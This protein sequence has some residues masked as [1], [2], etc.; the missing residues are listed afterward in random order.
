MAQHHTARELEIEALLR[1]SQWL[2]ELARSLVG[3][4]FTAE[5]L[6]QEA[7]SHA[8]KEA[9]WATGHLGGWVAGI[10]RNLAKQHFRKE[11]RRIAREQEAAYRRALEHSLP[12][13]TQ[14]APD[15]AFLAQK[16]EVQQILAQ[17]VL[18]L[19]LPSREVL[20]LRYY[21]DRSTK[22]IAAQLNL[23][24]SAVET[25][26]R[27]A[28]TRLRAQME[29]TL[30]KG[31]WALA[32]MPLLPP[33][34][35]PPPQPVPM[36]PTWVSAT[37][38][39]GL[40]LVVAMFGGWLPWQGVDLGQGHDLA[41]V[42]ATDPLMQ[43]GQTTT[44]IERNP[45]M[46]PPPGEPS[47]RG[48]R[49]H[50]QVLESQTNVPL[51]GLKPRF[52]YARR[53]TQQELAIQDD[54]S[55]LRL[56]SVPYWILRTEEGL[57][58]EQ[59]LV[60]LKPPKD[61]TVVVLDLALHTETHSLA[62]YSRGHTA[63]PLPKKPNQRIALEMVPR[64]GQASG[65]VVNPKGDPIPFAKVD[66]VPTV[67]FPKEDSISAT[68]V[69]DAHGRF[70]MNHVASNVGG[71]LLRPR[72]PG[73]VPARQ[74]QINAF[75]DAQESLADIEL[76]LAAVVTAKVVVQDARG[77][78]I[79]NAMVQAMDSLAVF[80]LPSFPGGRYQSEWSSTTQSNP[81]GIAE[82][83][84]AENQGVH[85]EVHAKDF[86]PW[87]QRFAA[88][89]AIVP[90]VLLPDVEVRVMVTADGKPIP[91]AQVRMVAQRH[92]T[93]R[94]IGE[95]AMTDAQGQALFRHARPGE[96]VEFAVSAPGYEVALSP[97][98]TILTHGQELSIPLSKGLS[99][100]GQVR[101]WQGLYPGRAV[102][103]V[104]VL[105]VEAQS[106]AWDQPVPPA[107]RQ[108]HRL[109]L[110]SADR[111]EIQQDGSFR[112][113]GLAPGR[114]RIWFGKR[115][116]P[117]GVTEVMAG[118]E[119]VVLTPFLNAQTTSVFHGVVRDAVTLQPVPDVRLILT[120]Y[121]DRGMPLK[122]NRGQQ[123]PPMHRERNPQGSY[124]LMAREPGWYSLAA[125][126]PSQGYCLI[127][128]RP[129]YFAAGDHQLDFQL[130]ESTALNFRVENGQGQSLRGVKVRVM[131]SHGGTVL[132]TG[133]GIRD[134]LDLSQSLER[135]RVT[136][137]SIPAS[138]EF[139]LELEYQ[140]KTQLVAGS[141]LRDS[142]QGELVVMML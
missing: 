39:A 23:E 101:D 98:I 102:P 49:W 28:R 37:V 105:P 120:A 43:Q 58:D 32:C 70:S 2:Q 62:T 141:P 103:V 127:E 29:K 79:A 113:E 133:E 65:R 116:L 52:H 21:G 126:V 137:G 11:S 139:Q 134:F 122:G 42:E 94:E 51:P 128:A 112:F 22:Q 40:L 4:A 117:W 59:G 3:D 24:P 63:Y 10:V 26:L 97:P 86:V 66:L 93:S 46:V 18:A 76:Q 57:S 104:F 50:F 131:D 64:S 81:E 15:P 17:Q 130:T 20:L 74:L 41:M 125:W 110:A 95:H 44:G 72:L 109:E 118:E 14:G 8:K 142:T 87:H 114:Y 73:F 121:S 53:A 82:V 33:H 6:L 119:D 5:D 99:I 55:Y 69:A 12:Q 30:G 45:V 7:L 27:R 85:F 13:E 36:L 135:G 9:K 35:A 140:G 48:L 68:V 123:Y 138:G 80:D 111:M 90:A 61:C 92:F 106:W 67:L 47:A 100:S 1:N 88:P 129:R 31:Q 25:R 34:M 56:K 107:Q 132:Q 89:P 96:L 136:L 71:F 54:P 83:L 75:S 60:W 38:A 91:K 124:R 84:V 77:V 78:P 115:Q 16:V 19:D 108:L